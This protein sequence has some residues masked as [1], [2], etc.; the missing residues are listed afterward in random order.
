MIPPEDQ[1]R[2]PVSGASREVSQETDGSRGVERHSATRLGVRI[3]LPHYHKDPAMAE[4]MSF[5]RAADYYDAT[6][7]LSPMVEAAVTEL[8]SAEL[9]GRGRCLEIGVGT[10]RIA[11]PL[12][13]AGV[14][15]AGIDLSRAMMLRIAVKAGGEPPF[16]L[17]QAD[18]TR[19]PFGASS[20]GGA[21][22]CHVLH[23]IPAWREAVA[24]LL[25]V[26]R[27][28]GVFLMESRAGRREQGEIDRV[29]HG[30]AGVAPPHEGLHEMAELDGVLQRA[31]ATLR[32]L[33]PVVEEQTTT[34]EAAIERLASGR[35]SG[36]WHLSDAQRMTA[37]EQTRRWARERFGPLD[38]PRSVTH[39][40]VWR[41][42][43]L[44]A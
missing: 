39:T 19:L 41:A 13:R 44:P 21:I 28:G 8:L 33:P 11:V 20:F 42:Y 23:L 35:F 6:R 12:W 7:A 26:L 4:A 2:D 31:G 15:M 10:G 3:S 36:T 29:F 37:A 1:T 40:I 5:D 16:P 43:T 25:R 17:A 27:P 14:P 9:A 18:A 34:L 30:A 24:E 32:L 38:A 22:A